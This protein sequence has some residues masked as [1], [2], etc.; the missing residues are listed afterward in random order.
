MVRE[1]LASEPPAAFDRIDE[2]IQDVLLSV[3]RARHTYDP[4]RPFRHWLVAIARYRSSTVD[5]D[6]RHI[7]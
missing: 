2:V 3:H 4:A 6:S 1:E 5:N 7:A